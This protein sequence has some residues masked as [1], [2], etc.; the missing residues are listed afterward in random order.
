MTKP[1]L[2]ASVA[3]LGAG[4]PAGLAMAQTMIAPGYYETV[5][6]VAGDPDTEVTRDCV[7]PA[8]A[9]SRTLETILAEAT[10]GKC[11]FTQRQ[12]GGGRFALTGSCVNEGVKS[13]FKNTGTYTPTSFSLNLVSRTVIGGAPIDLNLTTTS[14]RIAAACPAGAR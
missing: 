4:L 13:T 14:R 6:R 5:T 8:E 2:I 3:L 1:A 10:E 7:T 11:A 12:V 9:K